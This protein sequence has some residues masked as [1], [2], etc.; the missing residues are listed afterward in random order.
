VHKRQ[1]SLSIWLTLWSTGYKVRAQASGRYQS[2]A[3]LCKPQAH[4]LQDIDIE[5]LFE[6]DAAPG[7]AG[8]AAPKYGLKVLDQ[9][10]SLG[11]IRALVPGPP[12]SRLLGEL[13]GGSAVAHRSG[14]TGF[15]QACIAA[16]TVQS[17]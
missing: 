15:L 16:A 2:S 14:S 7:D 11:P 8:N 17:P 4:P 3:G 10:P 5:A 1:P 9:L 6:A 12:P 13:Q